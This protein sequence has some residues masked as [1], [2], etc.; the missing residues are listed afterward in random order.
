[1]RYSDLRHEI[2]Q[3]TAVSTIPAWAGSVL[4]AVTAGALRVPAVRH[5]L[6]FFCLPVERD[7]DLGVCLHVWSP[8]LTTSGSSTSLVHCH[9]WDLLS[10]V[11]YGQ[12]SN[13]LGRISDGTVHRL[14]EVSGLG[15]EDAI[16]ATD[17]V[18]DYRPER[19][20]RFGA[21]QSYSLAAGVFHSTV[22]E[23]SGEAATVALGRMIRSGAD[24]SLGPLDAPSHTQRRHVCGDAE[25]ARAAAVA[26]A[27]MAAQYTH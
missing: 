22:I 23:G 11:L 17:R 25:S 13:V 26:T 21:G 1:M 9:S 19:L 15:D 10:F 6:G 7:G 18:V 20:E 27:G 5:P 24:L 2:D 3:G 12:V 4:Q 8:Q 14:F 16:T